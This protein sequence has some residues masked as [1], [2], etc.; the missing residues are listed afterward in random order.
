VEELS[1]PPH[2]SW[3]LSGDIIGQTVT[4]PRQLNSPPALSSLNIAFKGQD[5]IEAFRIRHTLYR[6]LPGSARCQF[7]FGSRQTTSTG[8]Q[9]LVGTDIFRED[10]GG[11]GNVSIENSDG[12]FSVPKGVR[13]DIPAGVRSP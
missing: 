1:A 8:S 2:L 12:S 5:R 3:H 11:F 9:F 13:V 7:C 6:D 4:G 10:A